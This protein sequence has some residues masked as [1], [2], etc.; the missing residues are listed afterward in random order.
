MNTTA[1][2]LGN[3]V[4]PVPR[5]PRLVRPPFYGEL[6]AAVDSGCHVMLMG[7]RGS[8]KTTAVRL[9]AQL[10]GKKLH[11]I[12]CHADMTT[13]ELRGTPGL[14]AGN[15]TFVYSNLVHAARNGDYL[16]VD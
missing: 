16:L 2:V 11:T 13:E 6:E 14:N 15:S 1:S 4:M 3:A 9:L 7:P 5:F 10:R 12:P 8:G